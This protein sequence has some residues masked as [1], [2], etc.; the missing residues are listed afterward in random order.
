MITVRLLNGEQLQIPTGDNISETVAH[1][2]RVQKWQ[3]SLTTSENPN[4]F[5]AVVV[6]RRIVILTRGL[7]FR[8]RSHDFL[9]ENQGWMQTCKNQS[10]IDWC[11][12]SGVI[13]TFWYANPHVWQRLDI[14]SIIT[15]NEALEQLHQNHHDDVVD[16]LFS[17]RHLIHT[18]YWIRNKNERC[19]NYVLAHSEELSLHEKMLLFRHN[20]T[21]AVRYAY[22]QG[23]YNFDRNTLFYLYNP[24]HPESIKLHLTEPDIQYRLCPSV[25]DTGNEQLLTRLLEELNQIETRRSFLF[26]TGLASNPSDLVVDWF[27]HNP[28]RCV[29]QFSLNTNDRA[30]QFL[31]D[32]P[33]LIRWT[34][35]MRNPNRLAIQYVKIWLAAREEWSSIVMECL[36]AN[37][38]VEMIMWILDRID[39]GQKFQPIPL[40]EWFKRLS[41]FDEFDVKLED[42]F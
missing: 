2:L 33:E 15:S 10:I 28:M 37:P 17:H 31:I 29:E 11:L 19:I 42:I 4:E 38:N 9:S 34:R 3:V 12:D 24:H 36:L 41:A 14:T 18:R 27:L 40:E 23:K 20:H 35:F 7:H 30:V 8:P 25:V 39:A 5:F 21:D 6:P 22:D 1:E 13:S 16:Y 32:H 26:P